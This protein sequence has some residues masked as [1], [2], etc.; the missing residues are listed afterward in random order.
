MDHVQRILAIN[1]QAAVEVLLEECPDIA[2]L[3][4]ATVFSRLLRLKVTAFLRA[5]CTSKAKVV[6]RHF[7]S[8]CVSLA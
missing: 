7:K 1:S 5:L 8:V 4:P 2:K 6:L 3:E